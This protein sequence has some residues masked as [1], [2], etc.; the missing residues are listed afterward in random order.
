M[1]LASVLTI[2]ILYMGCYDNACLH[3]SI[4]VD[5]TRSG[6]YRNRT[7]E[8]DPMYSCP[9]GDTPLGFQCISMTYPELT[10][11]IDKYPCYTVENVA[12]RYIEVLV[13]IHAIIW[14]TVYN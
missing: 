9:D 11:N 8:T 1:S 14:Y 7:R 13:S 4:A 12:G 6:I 10:T 3:H 5:A 2:N